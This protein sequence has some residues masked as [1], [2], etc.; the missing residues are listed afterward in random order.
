MPAPDVEVSLVNLDLKRPQQ[1]HLTGQP[2]ALAH[3]C[4]LQLRELLRSGLAAARQHAD[5]AQTAGTGTGTGA[6]QQY[7]GLLANG[8]QALTDGGGYGSTPVDFNFALSAW[9]QQASRTE[10]KQRQQQYDAAKE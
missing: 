6:G 2:G 8:Q 10:H 4:K 1:T 7:S 9:H 5:L 3:L